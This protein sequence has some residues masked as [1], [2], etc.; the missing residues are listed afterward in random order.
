M[1]SFIASWIVLLSLFAGNQVYACSLAPDYLDGEFGADGVSLSDISKH[2]HQIA[3]GQ[4]ID[5]AGSVQFLTIKRI[6]PRLSFFKKKKIHIQFREVPVKK[7]YLYDGKNEKEFKSFSELKSFTGQFRVPA[8]AANIIYGAGGPIAEIA[9]GSDCER[10]VMLKPNQNYLVYLDAEN[11]V[12]ANFPI[13]SISN[14][15]VDGAATL[16]SVPPAGQKP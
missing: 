13:K 2:A 9:H 12:Q 7:V 4:F 16:F 5:V 10:F 15:F 1:R 11:T 6:K 8:L 3:F 14:D